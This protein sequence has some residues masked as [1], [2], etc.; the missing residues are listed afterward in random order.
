MSYTIK[1][2]GQ[3]SITVPDG[4]IN[5]ETSITLVGKNYAGYGQFLDQNSMNLLQSNAAE[6]PPSNPQYGQLWW[7]ANAK[8]LNVFNGAL[9]KGIASSKAS[10][11]APVGPVVGDMW[12]NTVDNSLSV[13]DGN[14]W[15]LIGPTV[16]KGTGVLST[17][18]EDTTGLLHAVVEIL[19]GTTV[20]G[21]ISKDA[22][23]TPLASIPGF[24]TISPGYN[25]ATEINGVAQFYNG[26]ATNA[27]TLQGHDPAT[28][29]SSVANTSTVGTIK[30]LSNAGIMTGSLSNFSMSNDG[31]DGIL[32]N[33]RQSGNIT[34]DLNVGGVSTNVAQ[35]YGSN[36][37]VSFG[38]DITATTIHA[39]VIYSNAVV[40]GYGN[41]N[42]VT[43]LANPGSN[44][45]IVT[46]A[47][48]LGDGGLLSNL[49][50]TYSNA[51]VSTYLSN[52]GSSANIKTAMYFIG[53]GSKLT[54]ISAANVVNGY[55]NA[56][57]TYFLSVPG[58]NANIVTSQFF[59]GDGSKLTNI[60][61]A[62]VVG[63]YGDANVAAFLPTYSGDISGLN[64][65]FA[66]NA[67]VGTSLGVGTLG[68]GVVGEIRATNNITAFYG[69]DQ[70][71]KENVREIDDAL[72]IVEAIG[73]QFFDWTDDYIAE[74]GGEDGY[75]VTK[76]DYGFIAQRVQKVFP[77]AVRTREDG[78]LAVDYTKMSVLA[79]AAIA[80]LSKQRKGE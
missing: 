31:L 77:Q 19:V 40:G 64:A 41:G 13:Y 34:I 44:S 67:A 55:G 73:G 47:Y 45:N 21:I 61:V 10:S 70:K 8:V 9:F 3:P 48:F 22:T 69:S 33:D 50:P 38:G 56:N 71:Y 53:D 28:F 15:V 43:F 72:A 62:N 32:T 76:E 1:R 78:S 20:V 60:N 63:S 80:Q 17:Y 26:T 39:N 52:P 4:T 14:S 5:T 66:G 65:T 2:Y 24:V 30:V 7:D 12:F 51:I 11:T 42:V 68:S 36:G 6:S 49:P 75:F 29:M 16:I 58:S 54:N 25:V 59:V 57:V 74:R 35:F 79:F 37:N 23:F 18:I 27:L 46:S